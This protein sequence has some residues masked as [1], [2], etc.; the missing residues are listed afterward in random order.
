MKAKAGFSQESKLE[1]IEG[2]AITIIEGS[3]D[4]YWWRGQNNR[5]MLIGHFPRA[6][7]E[8]KRRLTTQDISKPL[9]NSFIHTGHMSAK[10]DEKSWG[11]PGKIDEIFL[12]NPLNPP[13]LL[14]DLNEAE[15]NQNEL[16]SCN[17]TESLA[18]IVNSMN[19]IDLSDECM[20]ENEI[21][22]YHPNYFRSLDPIE[23]VPVKNE[24]LDNLHELFNN[25]TSQTVPYINYQYNFNLQSMDNHNKLSSDVPIQSHTYYNDFKSSGYLN[26]EYHS[27][28][29]ANNSTNPFRTNSPINNNISNSDMRCSLQSNPSSSSLSSFRSF[30]NDSPV[31]NFDQV[32]PSN[33]TMSNVNAQPVN[34]FMFDHSTKRTTN[35][36]EL[37]NKVMNDVILDFDKLKSNLYK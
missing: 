3:P 27:V 33:S 37:L 23:P 13:D 6:V 24:N 19:L 25:A 4:R 16:V 21:N 34:K 18:D 5:T 8:P 17:Q 35:V 12:K 10:S 30:V 29:Y 26:T 14:E 1:I 28:S 20:R 31:N 32:S 36:D 9:K 7:L 22:V 2:D 11:H 15:T